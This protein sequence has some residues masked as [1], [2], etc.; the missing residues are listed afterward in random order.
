MTDEKRFLTAEIRTLDGESLGV[1]VL[2]P[3]E[4]STGSRGYHGTG[5]I[6][7]GDDRL[8][9]QVQAVVI[10]SKAAAEGD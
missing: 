7:L 9:C 5:K 10:G 6:A 4:F 1:L 3:K 2:Q 8:Q